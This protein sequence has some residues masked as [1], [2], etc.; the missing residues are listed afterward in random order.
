MASHAPTAEEIAELCKNITDRAMLNKIEAIINEPIISDLVEELDKIKKGSFRD[1][2]PYIKQTILDAPGN[3]NDKVT[4]MRNVIDRGILDPVPVLK[5]VSTKTNLSTCIVR[6]VLNDS[7]QKEIY[8]YVANQFSGAAGKSKFKLASGMAVGEGE[9]F[10]IFMMKGVTKGEVGDLQ[11]GGKDWEIKAIAARWASAR[12]KPAAM[13]TI[14]TQVANKLG[15]PVSEVTPLLFDGFKATYTTNK[16][17]KAQLS[18]LEIEPNDWA[19]AVADALQ[20]NF[21]QTADVSGF[22]NVDW[23]TGANGQDNYK[24]IKKAYARML[25]TFYKTSDQWATL[26]SFNQKTM[27]VMSVSNAGDVET[28]INNGV[29]DAAMSSVMMTTGGTG[30]FD[31][32][33]QYTLK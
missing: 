6:G 26:T 19:N 23:I 28:A 24:R 27:N 4:F 18:K 7:H 31:T 13:T 11:Y 17:L 32:S 20:K 14:K 15:K 16:T 2:K 33:P 25:I 8:K 30:G 29:L 1:D 3:V 9:G 21:G 22:R 10:F 12:K 5:S